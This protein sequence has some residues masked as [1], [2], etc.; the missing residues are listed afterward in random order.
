L[1]ADHRVEPYACRCRYRRSACAPRLTI[2]SFSPSSALNCLCCR[3]GQTAGL[4]TRAHMC[5]EAEGFAF[6]SPYLAELSFLPCLAVVHSPSCGAVVCLLA[7]SP[8]LSPRSSRW[9][10][11]VHTRGGKPSSLAA[12]ADPCTFLAHSHTR[13]STP[14]LIPRP[15]TPSYLAAPARNLSPP[16]NHHPAKG[17]GF[18]CDDRD[19]RCIPELLEALLTSV[20][21]QIFSSPISSEVLGKFLNRLW[22]IFR[23]FELILCKRF[24]FGK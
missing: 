3:R 12:V 8:C 1:C 2:L 6:S 7:P 18:P 17:R 22:I 16:L 13:A 11:H 23:L 14:A 5:R 4:H 20:G 9:L 21:L 10:A 19:L 15:M 24:D